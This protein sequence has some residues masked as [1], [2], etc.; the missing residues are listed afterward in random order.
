MKTR[1][2]MFGRM[3]RAL[4]RRPGWTIVG[5][6]LAVTILTWDVPR[7]ELAR[8]QFEPPSV[9]LASRAELRPLTRA[10]YLGVTRLLPPEQRDDLDRALVSL[11]GISARATRLFAQDGGPLR[12]IQLRGLAN[13]P[14]V[15]WAVPLCPCG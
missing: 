2:G 6:L 1:S 10:L 3:L 13:G 11:E 14:A 5:A 12:S 9:E 15:R 4:D 7:R 8:L